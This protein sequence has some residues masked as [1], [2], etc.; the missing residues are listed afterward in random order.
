[1]LYRNH[2][3]MAENLKRQASIKPQVPFCV[4]ASH[5]PGQGQW[6]PISKNM[7]AYNPNVSVYIVTDTLLV[8]VFSSFLTLTLMLMFSN[9][10]SNVDVST[11]F[12]HLWQIN[13]EQT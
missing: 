6:F 8:N 2:I 13:A 11:A 10:D 9:P 7:K 5:L 4:L 1:M 12:F 3:Y